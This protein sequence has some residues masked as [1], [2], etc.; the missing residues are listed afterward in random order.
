MQSSCRQRQKQIFL[1]IFGLVAGFI[2]FNYYRFCYFYILIVTSLTKISKFRCSQNFIL[3][4]VKE[5]LT[6]HAYATKTD[7]RS[8]L[9]ASWFYQKQFEFELFAL[10]LYSYY[11]G[12]H[13]TAMLIQLENLG[14]GTIVIV[15]HTLSFSCERRNCNAAKKHRKIL[16]C[17]TCKIKLKV[18]VIPFTEVVFFLSV[19]KKIHQ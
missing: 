17:F 3:V 18:S 13:N 19:L 14:R 16:I 4:S 2:D 12:L 9:F 6:A 7:D 15:K 11:L 8:T 1:L 5:R 10:S